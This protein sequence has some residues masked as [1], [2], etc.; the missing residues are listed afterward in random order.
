MSSS[1]RITPIVKKGAYIYE[2][3]IPLSYNDALDEYVESKQEQKF[4][5]L[6]KKSSTRDI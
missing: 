4:E 6:S 1:N 5:D 2:K 3:F